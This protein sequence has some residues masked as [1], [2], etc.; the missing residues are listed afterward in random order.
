MPAVRWQTELV[1]SRT[2][3]YLLI[4]WQ[5]SGVALL[6]LSPWEQYF[7]LVKLILLVAMVSE[8]RRGIKRLS[9]RV[10]SLSF[11]DQEC[12]YWHQQEWRLASPLY[13]LSG[14]VLVDWRSGK[15]RQ[16]FWLM[17]DAMSERDWRNLRFYWLKGRNRHWQ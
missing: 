6:I 15:Q 4:G 3:C 11:D 1:I 8:G 2:A 16:R 12:W 13:W 10:G 5:A 14:A 17:R 7:Y 9:A